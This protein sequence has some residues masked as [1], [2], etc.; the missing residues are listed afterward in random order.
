[1]VLK[2]GVGK[3]RGMGPTDEWVGPLSA[4]V[5]EFKVPGKSRMLHGRV[6]VRL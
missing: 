2:K 1:M 5:D 6:T 4:T 3:G